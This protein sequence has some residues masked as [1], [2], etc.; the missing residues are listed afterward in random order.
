VT[1]RRQPGAPPDLP[2]YSVLRL[3]GL[4][5]FAD[6]FLYHQQL[7]ERD[8][9]IKVLLEPSL[10]D[11][12]RQRFVVEA[13]TMARLSHHPAIVTVHHADFAADG[14][15]YLVMEYCSGPGMAERYRAEQMSVA[16]CLRIGIRLAGAVQSAHDA[17]I[18]HRDI[19]PANVLTTDFGWP[20]LT[21]FG[22]AATGRHRRGSALG[23]SIPWSPP[24]LLGARPAG[25]E[26]SDVYSLGAT[27]YSLLAGRSPF[28][29][30]GMANGPAELVARIE[31]MPLP[32]IGRPQVPA[33]LS[34]VLARAM[35]RAPARRYSSALAVAR[36][37]QQVEA[38]LGLP[39][40][41]VDVAGP[42][43]AGRGEAAAGD[44]SG[45]SVAPQPV[46]QLGAAATSSDETRVRPVL[47]LG[48]AAVADAP[49]GVGAPDGAGVAVPAAGRPEGGP[50]ARRALVGA[51]VA[52]LGLALVAGGAAVLANRPASRPTPVATDFTAGP[53]TV[54]AV[55]PAPTG[56]TGARQADGSTVFTW[57]NPD[58]Q[59][60]DSYLWGQ[61]TLTGEVTLS[62]VEQ[63]RVV[64]PATGTQ[65]Q[66]CV[67]VSV[68]RTDGRYSAKPAQGCVP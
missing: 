63:P 18:L 27:I 7:P 53:A 23:M 39:V 35:A 37:F 42:D 38:S 62:R 66:V 52:V 36:A 67:Q 58:P 30:L 51:V 29:V 22:I 16:E 47:E 2:G 28:E 46:R 55:V 1:E 11:A 31:R 54:A 6:V 45:Q 34:E 19:K 57:Q 49:A 56:L 3:I 9:A 14:R 43:S 61:L 41:S 26:R 4:G 21:D 59:P 68:R 5:G 17:G 32:A 20:A 60:G 12:A 33:E 64:V 25:D 24:E 10:D 50:G 8:V 15:P 44:R 13:N 65:G 40:T 48:A